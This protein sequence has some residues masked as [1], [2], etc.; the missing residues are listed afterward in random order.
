MFTGFSNTW[1]KNKA[2]IATITAL[3]WPTVLEQALQTV[4]QYADTAMVGQMGANASAAVGL[5]ATVTWLVNGPMFAMGIGVLACISQAIGAKDYQ[6]A[7]TASVQSFFLALA[8]GI[9]LTIITL[10]VSP[11]LPGWLGASEEIRKDASIYFF[12]TCIPMVFRAATIIFGSVLRAAGETKTPMFVNAFMNVINI[13]L[14]FFLIGNGVTLGS[15]HLWG[16]GLG[17]AGAA[18]ATAISHAAGGTLMIIALLK[19]PLLSPKGQS[20]RIC[21]NVMKQCVKVGIPVALQR[22]VVC[23]GQVYFTSLVTDLGTISV[24]AH[25]IALTAE[26]AFYIPGYGM[27]TAASTLAGNAVGERNGK[28]LMHMSRV[29]TLIAMM[30]MTITGGLLFLFPGAIMSIFTQDPAVISQGITVLKIV[31][32]SEPLFAVAIIMEGLFNGI[33]DTRSPFFISVI[34]MWGV[35]IVF[36]FICVR[37]FHLGLNAVW[38]C[39]VADNVSKCFLLLFRFLQGKWKVGLDLSY[40]ENN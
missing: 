30:I 8:L 7:K 36:T 18:I 2:M 5:T 14:N 39:M 28:K 20:F 29:I 21:P 26:Q 33:G 1:Q 25:S 11:F 15:F 16:A 12:I 27:E 17:V 40:S 37:V 35:R 6:R 4:V 31:A 22:I 23:F 38:V 10:S 13:I 34:T 9:V 32:V 19:N 3:A 24:A